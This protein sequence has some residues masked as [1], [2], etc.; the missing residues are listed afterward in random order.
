[1]RIL[2]GE[3][4]E[5]ARKGAIRIAKAGFAFVLGVERV[6]ERRRAM[7]GAIARD[8]KARIRAKKMHLSVELAPDSGWK[9]GVRAEKMHLSEA[10]VRGPV[11]DAR[12]RAEKMHLSVELAPD[13]TWKMRLR[14]EK[15][16]LSA[17]LAPD[18]G[19][20]MR[21]RAGKMRVW[22]RSA[23]RL[24]KETRLSDRRDCRCPSDASFSPQC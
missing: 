11:S 6:S 17:R 3:T 1:M 5:R 22:P 2:R 7:T 15:M 13:S 18:S 16:H 20:T 21:L 8:R 14:A 12:I 24:A 23:A 4:L 9:M 19:W 10:G